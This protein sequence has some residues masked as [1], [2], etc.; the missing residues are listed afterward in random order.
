MLYNITRKKVVTKKSK[1]AKGFFQLLRG[2]MFVKE[3]DFNYALIFH[4]PFTGTGTASIHSLFVF[5]PVDV[6]FLDKEKKVVE[7]VNSLKPF[8][9]NYCPK[10]GSKYFVELPEGNAYKIKIGNFLGWSG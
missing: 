7:I 8:T 10:K 2:L 1:V 9:T 4:L 6:V 5:F 3:K